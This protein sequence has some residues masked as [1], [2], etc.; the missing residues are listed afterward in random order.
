VESTTVDEE[1]N[2][3]NDSDEKEVVES[4]KLEQEE[5]KDKEDDKV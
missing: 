1:A 5:H 4:T 3:D 2:K